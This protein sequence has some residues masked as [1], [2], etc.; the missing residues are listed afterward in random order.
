MTNFEY[1]EVSMSGFNPSY[2]IQG[3]VYYVTGSIV[4]TEDGS[5][6]HDSNHCGEVFKVAKK[7][8]E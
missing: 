2:R 6:L 7:I 4:Y 5:L 8:F 1:N 3:Q